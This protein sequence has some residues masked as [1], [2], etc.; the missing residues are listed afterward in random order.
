MIHLVDAAQSQVGAVLFARRLR[1]NLALG[2]GD[3]GNQSIYLGR[4]P[5]A[6]LVGG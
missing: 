6:H 5:W 2:I 1:R 3:L 4:V